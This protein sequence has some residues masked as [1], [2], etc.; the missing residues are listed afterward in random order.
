MVPERRGHGYAFDLL[1]EATHL[2]VVERADRIVA[3]TDVTNIPI[4]AT[5]LQ[6][7]GPGGRPRSGVHR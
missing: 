2:L 5:E 6:A 4:A 7:R 1:A 3:G